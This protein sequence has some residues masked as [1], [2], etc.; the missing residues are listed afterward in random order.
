M[1][2]LPISS[3]EE[4]FSRMS[5]AYGSAW[6]LMWTGLDPQ[7]VKHQWATE[8]GAYANSPEKIHHALEH[9]P[10]DKP[11]NSLQFR[12]LCMNAP[13]PEPDPVPQLPGMPER[14]Q[15]ISRLRAAFQ[16]Y[17]ELRKEML[18]KPKE[19]AYRMQER[20]RRGER[21]TAFEQQAAIKKPVAKVED[22]HLGGHHTPIANEDL[23]PG[24]RR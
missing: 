22:K 15:D 16:R 1:S 17:K 12:V 18:K 8:L 6:T 21:L 24:M 19:W 7:E 3:V 9:L 23:P 5:V 11:P 20:E 14:K 2:S 13:E 4:I 10:V